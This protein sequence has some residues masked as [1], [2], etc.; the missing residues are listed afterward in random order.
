MVLKRDLH[1]ELLN[2][3]IDNFTVNIC[4]TVLPRNWK[5]DEQISLRGV[6]EKGFETFDLLCVL[7]YVI[8]RLKHI[9]RLNISL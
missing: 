8:N 6:F 3:S 1:F 5:F 4:F 7:D 9:L 2:F